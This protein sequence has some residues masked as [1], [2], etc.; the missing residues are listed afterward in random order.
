MTKIYNRFHDLY[1]DAP[2]ITELRSLHVAMDRAVLDAYGC[3]DIPTDC[4]FLLEYA[5]D[6]ATWGNRRMPYRWPDHTRD[7]VLARL[8]AL[9]ATRAA[10][11]ADDQ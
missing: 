1:E 2:E 8:L 9:D 6:E 7:E 4:E 5:I 10:E 11:E 3:S